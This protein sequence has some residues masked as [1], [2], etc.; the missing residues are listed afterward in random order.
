MCSS[1]LV[2][3]NQTDIPFVLWIENCLVCQSISPD[4]TAD[5]IFLE[6]TTLCPVFRF[7]P[8][9]FS[10]KM[11]PHITSFK[12]LP[13]ITR[14]HYRM[15]MKAIALSILSLSL[16][17]LLHQLS[18]MN[19]LVAP[20]SLLRSMDTIKTCE[21]PD[22]GTIGN[23]S[24]PNIPNL[25]H[26][27][28]KT[29]DVRT[30]SIDASHD[31]WKSLFEPLNYTVRLWTEDDIL[32]LI[33]EEYEWLLPVYKS[34][35]QNIQ[36]ADVARLVVIHSEGGIYADLDVYP[37]SVDKIACIQ[38]LR[39]QAVFSPTAGNGG[40]SN[41]FFM[42]EKESLFLEFALQEVLLRGGS[43]SDRILLPYLQVFWSTGPLMIT[44]VARRFPSASD[45]ISHALGVMDERYSKSVVRHKAGRSWHGWDG[46]V[47]NWFGDNVDVGDLLL[48]IGLLF[49]V[50]VSGYIAARRR[51]G[52]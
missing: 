9:S 8:P 19:D 31:S 18:Y 6:N 35:P 49:G 27:I 21:V 42:A 22:H 38:N 28:W 40:V 43:R 48:I 52:R 2:P 26:Q 1:V 33:E 39:T 45:K 34:Y 44:A 32:K 10:F 41:H 5:A 11:V 29:S 47:L 24:Q 36:R 3:L 37:A 15:F 50:S 25:V 30:Y 46:Q 20:V 4:K 51:C 14:K 23:N 12:M 13:H 16:L 7:H 17:I